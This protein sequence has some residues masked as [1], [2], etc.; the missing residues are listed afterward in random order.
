MVPFTVRESEKAL[1]E[2]R[3]PAVPQ[4]EGKAE[5]LP[6]VGYSGKAVLTPPVGT[7][8]GMIVREVVPGISVF[9]IVLAY[10]PPLPLAQ[11]GPPLLPWSGL[12]ACFIQAFLFFTD[13]Q[14]F[15]VCLLMVA[16]RYPGAASLNR[17]VIHGVSS[18][19]PSNFFLQK[20]SVIRY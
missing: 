18:P 19:R 10:G 15:H 14:R 2:D 12:F 9:A 13:L 11:I 1:L 6:G 8:A 16:V 3:V 7:G 17:F 4:G 5:A 20:L